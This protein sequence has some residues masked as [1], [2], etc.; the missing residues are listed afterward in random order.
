MLGDARV[1]MV[2]VSLLSLISRL[3]RLERAANSFGKGPYNLFVPSRNVLRYDSFPNVA[4]IEADKFVPVRS[5]EI[6]LP[7]VSHSTLS[8]SHT[9]KASNFK[10]G[11]L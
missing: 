5:N 11:C 3:T 8:H 7:R 6:T 9:N 4:G 1:G 10:I 2:P